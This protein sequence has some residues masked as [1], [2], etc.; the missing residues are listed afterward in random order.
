MV[1]VVSDK[2]R[3]NGLGSSLLERLFDWYKRTTGQLTKSHTATL[4]TNYRCHPSILMMASSLFYEGTLVS[5]SSSEAH[6]LAPY[7]IVFVCT[8][9]NQN[10]FE[11]CPTEN[12]EEAL[13]LIN[14]MIEYI[15][16]WPREAP[17]DPIGLLA[18]TKQQVQRAQPPWF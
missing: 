3:D 12:V 7:P 17:V 5:R 11:N 15:I 9:M 10:G 2:A 1:R 13:L 16:S 8:S 18:S 4:L 14:K 6:P